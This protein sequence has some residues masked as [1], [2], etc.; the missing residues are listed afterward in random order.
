ML[1][2]STYI[3]VV[4]HH[5]GV[6]DLPA[7]PEPAV[8]R[9]R[10]ERRQPY[11]AAHEERRHE[12]QC[13]GVRLLHQR[14]RQ[15]WVSA[16]AIQAVVAVIVW[17]ISICVLY[18]HKVSDVEKSIFNSIYSRI[19][20]RCIL[21]LVTEVKNLQMEQGRPSTFLLQHYGIAERMPPTF[22]ALVL[23]QRDFESPW[24][25]AKRWRYVF[26]ASALPS[27]IVVLLSN[28][29]NSIS[30]ILHYSWILHYCAMDCCCNFNSQNDLQALGWVVLSIMVWVIRKVMGLL[31]VLHL[32]TVRSFKNSFFLCGKF[33]LFS[34]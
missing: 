28:C 16:A 6:G 29:W 7:Y 12:R 19:S 9:R 3:P 23:H 27:L 10:R 1:T 26:Y 22:C 17:K 4:T 13:L 33:N 24:H 15:G 11:F 20:S 14:P 30:E 2:A 32:G 18:I 5:V 31:K 21:I 25:C 8:L 34:F